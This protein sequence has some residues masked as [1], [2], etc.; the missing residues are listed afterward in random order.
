MTTN[1]RSVVAV[2]V[3]VVASVESVWPPGMHLRVDDVRA[4]DAG[5][6][7]AVVDAPRS[8]VQDERHRALGRSGPR[9]ATKFES[10]GDDAADALVL[11]LGVGGRPG[12][13]RPR[14]RRSRA[15]GRPARRA[16]PPRRSSS[17]RRS[18]GTCRRGPATPLTRSCSASTRCW[19]SSRSGPGGSSALRPSTFC[20]SCS[21]MLAEL[22]RELGDLDARRRQRV[23]DRRAVVLRAAGDRARPRPCSSC[24]RRAWTS[25]RTT[26][27]AARRRRAAATTIAT[28][29]SRRSSGVSPRGGAG[30]PRAARC[31]GRRGAA[32]AR[33][34][35]AAT[36]SVAGSSSKKSNSMSSSRGSIAG[37]NV[38][39]SPGRRRICTVGEP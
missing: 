15:A 13:G 37:P 12:T 4:V 25:T 5:R 18:A 35:A 11:H 3:F 2:T 28:S 39:G 7:A 6:R 27:S 14:R 8:R 10:G 26:G 1:A 22:R 24:R 16:A 38:P 32:A 29:A 9:F 17:S 34:A 31:R 30:R 33:A 19:F 20:R 36:R 23:R 21:A